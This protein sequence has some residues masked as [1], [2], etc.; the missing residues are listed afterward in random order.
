M[1]TFTDLHLWNFLPVIITFSPPL[2]FPRAPIQSFCLCL[3]AHLSVCLTFTSTCF[4]TSINQRQRRNLSIYP[5]VSLSRYL[6]SRLSVHLFNHTR[7]SFTHPHSSLFHTPIIFSSVI[8]FLYC[9]PFP[10]IYFL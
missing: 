7:S 9:N 3:S 2:P 8:L 1:I 5:S 10:Y 6:S 4:H